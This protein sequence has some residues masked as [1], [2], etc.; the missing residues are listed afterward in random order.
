MVNLVLCK[1]KKS[2]LQVFEFWKFH[3][4][5]LNLDEPTGKIE[6]RLTT[7]IPTSCLMQSQN[8]H[9]ICAGSER[10]DHSRLFIKWRNIYVATVTKLQICKFFGYCTKRDENILFGIWHS[11]SFRDHFPTMCKVRYHFSAVPARWGRSWLRKHWNYWFFRT[12]KNGW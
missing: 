5:L 10:Q 9:A 1:M 11:V 6:P 8:N 3:S 4:E 2:I 12:P 7:G